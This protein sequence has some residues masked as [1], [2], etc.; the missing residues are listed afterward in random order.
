MRILSMV[1]CICMV[2]TLIPAVTIPVSAADSWDTNGNGVLEILAIGNSFSVDAL[3]YAWQI[4]EDLGIEKIVIGNL[5]IGGCSLKTH[6]TNAS[7]DKAAYTYYYNDNGTWETTSGYKI[8]T[9][10]SERNWDYVSLQQR[11]ADSGMEST[12]NEDLTTLVN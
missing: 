4:A 11:S 6:A 8:S 2:L 3:E 9:A 7:G 10:L 12:Y 1:L 5:Y